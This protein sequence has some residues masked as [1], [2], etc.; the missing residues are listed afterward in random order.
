MHQFEFAVEQSWP[1][2]SWR[3][4]PVVVGVSGGPDSVA[5][6]R[7]L[8]AIATPGKAGLIAAHFNHGLRPEAQHD[9]QFV[10]D[11]CEKLSLRCEVGSGSITPRGGE[12]LESAARKARYTFLKQVA[13]D[14]GAR[15]VAVAHTADDQAET[16]LH[17]ILRG[18]GIAGVRGMP[19]VRPLSHA[20]SLIRPLLAVSRADVRQYLADIGQP[21]CEDATNADPRFTRSRIR[22]ELMPMLQERFNPQVVEA[23]LRLSQ[24]ATGTQQ[25]VET[26]VEQ[27][28]GRAVTR[29]SPTQLEVTCKVE[30]D[31]RALMEQPRHLVRELFVALWKEQVWPQQRM[32]FSHWD[33]LADLALNGKPGQ[34]IC[35]P[36]GVVARREDAVLKLTK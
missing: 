5:L 4:V 25:F 31:C 2:A 27:L 24:A 34:S 26:L 30:L 12:G 9:E 35:L 22:H 17:R 10:R 13:H 28:H 19:R 8:H 20:T 3:D 7:A 18:T 11:L 23:L 15:Y 6:L 32:A 36:D 1:P 21:Y 14:C 33:A 16:V 29:S